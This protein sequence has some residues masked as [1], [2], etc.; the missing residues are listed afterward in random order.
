[1]PDDTP[2]TTAI[3]DA[4]LAQLRTEV[5]WHHGHG[6]HYPGDVASPGVILALLARLDAAE[7]RADAFE[8]YGRECAAAM[9]NSPAQRNLAAAEAHLADVEAERDRYGE[10]LREITGTCMGYGCDDIARD[11]L[12][13]PAPR[14]V[15][16]G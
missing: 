2:P 7:A 9:V 16:D 4:Q 5:E 13:P 3:S 10:A 14:R 6:A 8:K 15:T 12:K 1:M 11:A